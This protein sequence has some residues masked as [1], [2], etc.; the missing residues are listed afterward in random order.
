MELVAGLVLRKYSPVTYTQSGLQSSNGHYRPLGTVG[1]RL[2]T[3]ACKQGLGKAP[4]TV[5]QR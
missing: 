4:A 1:A 5:H 3:R 2:Q